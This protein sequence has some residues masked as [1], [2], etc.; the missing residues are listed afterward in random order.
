MQTGDSGNRFSVNT[1]LPA[2][3]PALFP[4]VRALSYA[5]PVAEALEYGRESGLVHRDELL[6]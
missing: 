1:A 4:T 5:R 3:R 2:S 6:S